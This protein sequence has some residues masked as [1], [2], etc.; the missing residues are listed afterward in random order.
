MTKLDEYTARAAE[1]LAAFEGAQNARDRAHHH[2]AHAVWRRLIANIA[3]DEERAGKVPPP[4]IK[5]EKSALAGT[6][7]RDAPARRALDKFDF[8]LR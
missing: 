8:N 5:S 3:S 4:P 2:R 1:S 7:M 6:A